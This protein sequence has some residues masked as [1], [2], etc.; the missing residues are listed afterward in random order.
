[1]Y[2]LADFQDNTRGII[3]LSFPET[4]TRAVKITLDKLDRTA[5][6]DGVLSEIEVFGK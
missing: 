5:L 4:E 2:A 6:Q 3:E 1:M